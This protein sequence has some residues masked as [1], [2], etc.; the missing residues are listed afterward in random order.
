MTSWDIA[1]STSLGTGVAKTEINGAQP[2]TKPTQAQT[3]I[4]VVPY[5]ASTG[6]LTAGQSLLTKVIIESNSINL[7]PK[8]FI[9]PPVQ[10][11]LGTFPSALTP[12]LDTVECNTPLQIGATQ[13]FQIYGE[14]YIANT[15][16]NKLGLGLHYST[17]QTSAKEMF[18]DSVTNETNTGTAATTVQ[19]ENLTIN[20]GAF[21]E[22]ITPVLVNAVV[23]AQE[24]LIGTI[25]VSSN[26]FENSMPLKVPCQP[27]ATALGSAI[28]VGTA[29]QPVYK[30]IHMGMKSSCLIS[31]SLTLDEASNSYW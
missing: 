2:L 18:Y 13:Q 1:T 19:G 30:N 29:K 20:D 7:L 21:L 24:S 14:N 11:G 27:T 17:A 10:G 25:S 28:G 16:A 23:T 3:L 22:S 6:A 15:V 5:M 4:E 9:A 31:N 12:M 8:Q 26:D